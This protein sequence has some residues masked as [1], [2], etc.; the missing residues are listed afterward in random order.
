MLG[1]LS[2]RSGVIRRFSFGNL[3]RLWR[4][5][6][7]CCTFFY[8]LTAGLHAPLKPHRKIIFAMQG[9]RLE[10]WFFKLQ[11]SYCSSKPS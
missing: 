4:R 6:N 3:L 7:L 9:Y 5:N 2:E 8:N 10:L 1:V 11:T